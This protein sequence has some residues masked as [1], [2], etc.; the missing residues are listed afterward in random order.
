MCNL[1]AFVAVLLLAVMPLAAGAD[2]VRIV[3]LGD[4]LT[5]GYG[6]AA[7]QGLVPQL[8]EWLDAQGA[9]ALVV[10]AG[11]SGDTT[12][13]ARARL[14]WVLGEG[15]DG[16]MVALGGNDM[17]RGLPPEEAGANLA[18]I[19]EAA[20]ARDLPVLLVGMKAPP[21]WGPDY[22]TAFDDIYP[23]LAAR[24]GALLYPDFFAGLAAQG[25]D[26]ADPASMA[27]WMQPDGIHPSAEGAAVIAAAFGPS[28][29]ELIAQ[30]RKA[31]D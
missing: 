29:L 5:A 21:N 31:A 3:A 22:K 1:R 4:S 23:D 18:A 14:D 9:D 30:A 25:A 10:N 16:L 2:T 8:Q 24:H 12:A 6:L 13:A 15:A 20:Q 27:R 11:V 7:G 26:M 28:V 17:L 19:L